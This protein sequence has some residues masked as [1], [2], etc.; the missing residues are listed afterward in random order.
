MKTIIIATVMAMAPI[1]ALAEWSGPYVGGYLNYGSGDAEDDIEELP[2]FNIVG[3]AFGAFSGYNF[4]RGAVVY[5][6]EIDINT[7]GLSGNDNKYQGHYEITATAAFDFRVG[8]DAGVHL[9]YLT[10]G[11]VK[12]RYRS[13][14]GG[15][16]Y[17]GDFAE[18]TMDGYSFGIGMDWQVTDAGFM[19]FE[20]LQTKYEGTT[21]DYGSDDLHN[22]AETSVRSINVGY[23]MTF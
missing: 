21:F 2:S 12:S 9:P 14:H 8:Y 6:G 15:E 4:Q 1:A 19:R 5:G 10:V 3:A 22:M 20:V 16:E 18:G 7:G 13:E 23:A 11:I 17:Q